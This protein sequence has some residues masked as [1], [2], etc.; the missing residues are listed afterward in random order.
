M[1]VID[2]VLHLYL[3]S[4]DLAELERVLP[5]PLVYGVTTNPTLMRRAGSR[6]DQLPD[7]LERVLGL[8]A[9]AVHVQ[10]ASADEA[11]MVRDARAALALAPPGSIVPKIPATRAGFAA[12][13]QL[14]HEGVRVT[15]TAVYEPE[16]AVFAAITGAAY[17]APYLGRLVDQGVDGLAV[18]RR[19][20][21]LVSR[22]GS[23]TRLL[24]ASVRSRED[25]LSL[26]DIGVGAITVPPALIAELLDHPR[27]LQAEE[28]FLSDAG[29]VG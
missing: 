8:G 28:G 22:Y 14:A 29:S 7:F 13:S 17:A 20:Q 11:G 18:I 24:I 15:Y 2:P 1:S 12:G 16:Q 27:T 4:A 26:L 25:F 23:G 3:D 21:D 10:V 5:H 19:M 6:P 9:R